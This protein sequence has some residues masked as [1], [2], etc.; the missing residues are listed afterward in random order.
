MLQHFRSGDPFLIFFLLFSS[1]IFIKFPY[2]LWNPIFFWVLLIQI[3]LFTAFVPIQA[4][5]FQHYFKIQLRLFQEFFAIHLALFIT[6]Y[7][8]GRY[9]ECAG[10]FFCEDSSEVLVLS[11]FHILP[12]WRW[13]SIYSLIH[14]AWN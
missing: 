4:E 11:N 7:P 13:I 1:F 14:K 12:K 6:V 10:N 5:T 2:I 9:S 8:A 3:G